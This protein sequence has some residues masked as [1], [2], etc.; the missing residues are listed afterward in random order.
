MRALYVPE[1][2]WA[3]VAMLERALE[4]GMVAELLESDEEA[5]MKHAFS[6]REESCERVAEWTA[7]AM[8]Q[9]TMGVRD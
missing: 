9:M 5:E 4:L 7:K 1:D 2:E 6:V 3:P 8:A